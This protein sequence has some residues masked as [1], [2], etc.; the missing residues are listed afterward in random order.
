MNSLFK[1]T[2]DNTRGYQGVSLDESSFKNCLKTSVRDTMID[3]EIRDARLDEL[4]NLLDTGFSASENLLADLKALQESEPDDSR[5][6]RIGEAFAE[7]VLTEHFNCRFHWNELRDSRNPK[8]NKTGADLVGFIQIAESMLFLFG[9]VK[10]SSDLTNRP[11]QV[12]TNEDG[13]ENQ[14]KNLYFSRDKRQILITYL[15]SK[16]LS[17]PEGN[18]FRIDYDL[19]LRT[20]YGANQTYQLVGV[21]VRDIEHDD[22][23]VSL[24]YNR[25]KNNIIAP[26]GLNLIALYAPIKKE[27]WYKIIK[28]EIE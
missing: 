28:G 12:M 27:N 7:V 6:W 4:S 24:S 20:Y 2:D 13:V 17:L 8:G 9:E 19:A 21:L 3:R 14:L 23:D 26:V 5:T 16:T 11:P 25:L 22:K 15:K 1:H 18:S 10:T